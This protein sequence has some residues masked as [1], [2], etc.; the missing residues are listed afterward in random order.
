MSAIIKDP[1]ALAAVVAAGLA[2]LVGFFSLVINLRT[3][4]RQERR[5]RDL[6]EQQATLQT[7]LVCCPRTRNWWGEGRGCASKALPRSRIGS[8]PRFRRCE[9]AWS[10]SGSSRPCRSRT[11]RGASPPAR[12]SPGPGGG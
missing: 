10:S 6:A 8:S 4:F 9:V 3:A 11:I 5:Q 1:K 12:R 2:F 7:H